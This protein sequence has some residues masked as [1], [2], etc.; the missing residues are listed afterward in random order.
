MVL[1][2]YRLMTPLPTAT[3]KFALI[4]PMGG[5]PIG[6]ND[7]LIAAIAL[8]NQVTLVTAN[9]GEFSRVPNLRWEDWSLP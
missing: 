9:I 2:P 8:A 3:A 1:N 5:T 4:L 7:L 6:P